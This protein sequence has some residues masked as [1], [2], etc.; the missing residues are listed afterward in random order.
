MATIKQVEKK[1]EKIEHFRVE[2]LHG[3]DGRDVR[4]DKKGITQYPYE[5][6]LRGSNNVRDWQEGR[7]AEHYP[8]FEVRVLNSSGHNA[9]GGTLLTTIRDTYLE[10]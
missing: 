3:R 6:M 2:I 9:H 5:R 10:D 7:F 8:G 1:I 4:G